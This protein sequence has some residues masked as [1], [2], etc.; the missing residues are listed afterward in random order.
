M[1]LSPLTSYYVRKLLRQNTQNLKW[2][3][4]PGAGIQADSLSNLDDVL[5]SLYL[6]EAEIRA[7]ICSLEKLIAYHQVLVVQGSHYSQ[8]LL[9]TEKTIFW[10]LG[11]K[12]EAAMGKPPMMIASRRF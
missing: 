12:W 11:F 4:H 3:V 2:I 5:S 10:L 8:E 9:Q 1:Q 6:E 7:V